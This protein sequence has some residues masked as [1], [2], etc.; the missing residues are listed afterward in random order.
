M[1]DPKGFLKTARAKEKERPVADRVKDWRELTLAPTSDELRAQ[2]ETIVASGIYPAWQHGVATLE[3]LLAKTTDEAGLARLIR[4][5]CA[6]TARRSFSPP[7]ISRK[8][9]KWPTGSGSSTR[10]S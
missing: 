9:R 1:G 7:I 3:P 4:A 6:S 5:A 2:A 10:A 8:P